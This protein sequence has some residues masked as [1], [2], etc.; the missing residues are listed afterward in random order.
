LLL[1]ATVASAGCG[2][3]ERVNAEEGRPATVVYAPGGDCRGFGSGYLPARDEA[4]AS[5]LGAAGS[6]TNLVGSAVGGKEV[7][8]T[9][10]SPPVMI[11]NTDRYIEAVDDVLA[12]LG[13]EE[14]GKNVAQTVSSLPHCSACAARIARH[15]AALGIPQR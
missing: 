5:L 8:P 1:L 6:L 14:V 2:G 7:P 3:N 12:C 10:P 15:R 11:E 4:R 13:A 9:A